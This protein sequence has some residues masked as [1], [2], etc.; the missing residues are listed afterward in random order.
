M[1]PRDFVILGLMRAFS[2]HSRPGFWGPKITIL[3]K[4]WTSSHLSST[5]T[6]Q[7]SLARKFYILAGECSEKR[8][9]VKFYDSQCKQ[10]RYFD[11]WVFL[12]IASQMFHVFS[13]FIVTPIQVAILTV[14]L[15]R[16]FGIAYLA[17]LATMIMF[18]IWLAVL[19]RGIGKTR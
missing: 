1:L 12:S 11:I 14:L 13:S 6:G 18:L 19:A 3:C 15:F 2:Q 4:M 16:E 5:D 9:L 7:A 10:K 8:H 17:G